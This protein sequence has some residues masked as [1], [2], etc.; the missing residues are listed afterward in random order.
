MARRTRDI[1]GTT[2]R[3]KRLL[4]QQRSSWRKRWLERYRYNIGARSYVNCNNE[5]IHQ[6]QINIDGEGSP[7]MY[8]E[9]PFACNSTNAPAG[10][11]EKVA[12]LAERVRMGQAL[13]HPDDPWYEPPEADEVIYD[14]EQPLYWKPRSTTGDSRYHGANSLEN[15]L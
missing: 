11:P 3:E 6:T 12:V 14:Q 2:A 1:K 15:T 13:W 8:W 9:P 10:S 5:T 7:D 4:Q